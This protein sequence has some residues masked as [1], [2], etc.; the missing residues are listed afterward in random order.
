MDVGRTNKVVITIKAPSR[1]DAMLSTEEENVVCWKT[2]KGAVQTWQPRY[3]TIMSVS[4]MIITSRML[5]KMDAAWMAMADK[6]WE[7]EIVGCSWGM[8]FGSGKVESELNRL[9]V[10]PLYV[11]TDH[12]PV[13]IACNSVLLAWSAIDQ[14]LFHLKWRSILCLAYF[15]FS[16][17]PN[18]AHVDTHLL[19]WST[20]WL[21]KSIIYTPV[22]ATFEALD[23]LASIEILLDV[24]KWCLR[25]YSVHSW[26]L[27]H[28][29][30]CLPSSITPERLDMY[31]IYWNDSRK[32]ACLLD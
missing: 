21:Q 26:G 7:S 5:T 8:N 22:D 12:H 25:L 9:S 19:I 27:F 30:F 17:Y 18:V 29:L 10:S 31:C 14:E 16:S 1:D 13:T 4:Q 2:A 6:Q 23:F 15:L 11:W 20:K 3:K 32:S 24:I 28:P